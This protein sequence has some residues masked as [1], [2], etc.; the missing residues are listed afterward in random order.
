[1]VS[2]AEGKNKKKDT[3]DGAVSNSPVRPSSV[4]QTAIHIETRT[5]QKQSANTLAGRR[6]NKQGSAI[7]FPSGS[8]VGRFWRGDVVEH[9]EKVKEETHE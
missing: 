9:G 4:V 7:L 8:V 6:D 2:L 1:V 3:R 5:D